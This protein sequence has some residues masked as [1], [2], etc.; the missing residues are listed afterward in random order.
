VSRDSFWPYIITDTIIIMMITNLILLGFC[1]V[2]LYYLLN[3]AI[4]LP[5]RREAIEQ[6]LKMVEVKSGMRVAELGSG[7]G[8]IVIA[9]AQAGAEVDG[10]EI[11][12]LL[13]WWSKTRL[14]RKKII[15]AKI[16]TQSFW[17]ADLS[18]Y[19]I[20]I[21]FGMTHIMERLRVKFEK[22]L[23]P[24]TLIISNVFKIPGWQVVKEEGGVNL[25]RK[26]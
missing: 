17:S 2:V 1:L 20:I 16:C 21:V 26:A 5:T 23:N 24:G 11:N 9:F 25:Y 15:T 12:P 3:G 18:Q 10:Y 14:A 7:D 22:E 4:P 8:R 6:M 19:N 13:S